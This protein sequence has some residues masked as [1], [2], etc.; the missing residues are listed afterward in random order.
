MATELAHLTSPELERADPVLLVPVGATEQH[1]PHL[2]LGTD[3]ALAVALA[4]AAAERCG[5]VLVAPAVAYGSSGEHDGFAGTVSIGQRATEL[6]LVELCRSAN[7]TFRRIGLVCTH[8]GNADP[9]RRAAARLR[10]EGRDVRS[11]V[12]AWGGDAHAGHTETSLMLA[13]APQLVQTENAEP[14]DTR[15]L[16]QV[17]GTLRRQGIRAVSANGVLGDPAGADPQQGEELLDAA[18]SV[19][20]AQLEAWQ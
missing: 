3:T 20:V 7:A 2:P 4:N 6:L 1:G 13:V 11:F 10:E 19:L 18:T 12:P 9:V 15:P 8:G 14:G 5:D 17:I 16:T